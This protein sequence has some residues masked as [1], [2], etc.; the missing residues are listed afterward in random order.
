M[1]FPLTPKH[2]TLNDLE[3]PFC[4]KLFCAGMF[5]AVKPGFRS[6]ATLKLVSCNECCRQTLN[7]NE[8]LRHR[9]VSLRPHGF[10]VLKRT[11]QWARPSDRR[12]ALVHYTSAHFLVLIMLL[13]FAGNGLHRLGLKFYNLCLDLVRITASVYK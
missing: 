10:L 12:F 11:R 6:L 13:F 8:Q 2:V 3:S 9:A 4:L 1:A 5:G 7:R